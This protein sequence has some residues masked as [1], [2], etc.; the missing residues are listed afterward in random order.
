M[1]VTAG[2]KT[3]RLDAASQASI[4]PDQRSRLDD[5]GIFEARARFR[6]SRPQVR[7]WS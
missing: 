7:W 2:G 1:T 5:V 6:R 4:L 3:I